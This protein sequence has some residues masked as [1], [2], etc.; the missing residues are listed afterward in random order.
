MPNP[1]QIRYTFIDFDNKKIIAE[2]SFANP[3]LELKSL[4]ETKKKIPDLLFYSQCDDNVLETRITSVTSHSDKKYLSVTAGSQNKYL[5]LSDLCRLGYQASK[6][7][8]TEVEIPELTSNPH[9][10][11]SVKVFGLVDQQER[12]VWALKFIT[13]T[14]TSETI[15]YCRIPP[16]QPHN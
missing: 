10:S 5:Y 6:N 3:P 9:A 13:K 7:G 8:K 2:V 11:I 4:A 14:S 12:M 15:D 1:I 16:L